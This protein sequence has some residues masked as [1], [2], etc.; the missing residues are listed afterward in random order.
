[1][2]AAAEM[3]I[4]TRISMKRRSIILQSPPDGF[5]LTHPKKKTNL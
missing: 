3:S 4:I 1:L 5:S 2:S